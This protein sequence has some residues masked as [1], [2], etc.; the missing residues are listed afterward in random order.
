MNDGKSKAL[1][2]AYKEVKDT[3]KLVDMTAP[4]I[5]GYYLENYPNDPIGMLNEDI[6][7]LDVPY[8]DGSCAKTIIMAVRGI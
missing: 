4:Q 5:A 6:H 2:R 3:V 7:Q 1:I 8:V